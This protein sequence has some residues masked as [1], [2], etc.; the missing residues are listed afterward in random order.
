MIKVDVSQF[1]NALQNIIN[2]LPNAVEASLDEIGRVG[3]AHAKATTLYKGNNLRNNT[4]FVSEGEFTKAVVAD[5]PY[6]GYVEFGNNQ[7]GDKIY[8]KHA[9]ALRF[10]V[11]GQVIFRKW[12]R[13]HGP[14]PFMSQ[15]RDEMVSQGT[16]I[17]EKHLANLLSKY[18]G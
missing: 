7:Q 18:S 11:E 15:A 13:A 17:I 1:V 3:E 9:K 10:E 2:D 5:T 8:P 12:V 14:L 6:A 16:G 4:K